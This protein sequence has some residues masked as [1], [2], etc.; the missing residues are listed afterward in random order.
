MRNT[1]I[2]I[3]DI[4]VWIVVVLIMLSSIVGG[5]GAG[6]ESGSTLVGLLVILLGFV[7]AVLFA[8]FLF[9]IYSIYENSRRTADALERLVDERGLRG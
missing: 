4:L 3:F 1:I 9:M 8:G 5:V 6:V 7:S 2:R